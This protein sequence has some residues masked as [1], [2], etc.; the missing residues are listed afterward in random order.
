MKRE[1]QSP[2]KKNGINLDAYES[3]LTKKAAAPRTPIK[4]DGKKPA[5]TPIK[6]LQDMTEDEK[7]AIKQQYLDDKL[8]VKKLTLEIEEE[9]AQ[10]QE[11]K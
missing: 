9:H 10:Y 7:L 2:R 11:N 5:K 3:V 1:Q 8:E 6:N 4:A